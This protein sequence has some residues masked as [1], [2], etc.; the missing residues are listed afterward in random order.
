MLTA[1]GLRVIA[2]VADLVGSATLVALT[3]T[4]VAEAIIPGAVYR[5]EVEIEPVAGEIDQVTAVLV[6]PVTAAVNCCVLPPWRLA[7][8]GVRLTATAAAGL[9]VTAAVA[10]FVGS[11]TLVALTVTVV[12]E[13]TVAGAVYRPELERES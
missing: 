10:D 3:V 7:E 1:T 6:L 9:S 8:S 5:P 2:A 12:A 13:E 4:V 11:A